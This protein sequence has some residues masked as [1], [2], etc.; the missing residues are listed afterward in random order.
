LLAAANAAY[1]AGGGA[2]AEANPADPYM[3]ALCYFNALREL[4]GARRIVE[5]EVRERVGR[6][7]SKR[8]RVEPPNPVLVDRLIGD[9]LELTSRVSTDDVAKAKARLEKSFHGAPDDRV[10]V[11][12][13]TN[14]ISGGLDSTRLGL[15]IVQGQPKTAAEYIQATSRVGR[16]VDKPGLV[17]TV[18]NVH[19]PRDRAHY[20]S[21][22]LFHRSF[23]RS[24]EATSVTP[25][26]ARALD[27]SLAAVVVSVA[28]HLRPELTPERAV[29]RLRDIPGYRREIIDAIVSRA[30]EESVV[31]GRV[32]LE[33]YIE[34]LLSD[35]ETVV[36]DLE[37]RV[38]YGDRRQ[39][40]QLL[41]VPLD[42][43]LPNLSGSHRRFVAARSMRDV[44]ANVVLRVRDPFGNRFTAEDVP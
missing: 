3:T 43:A 16:A 35:W 21:F 22:H 2:E 19:K 18:L 40:Q 10:D 7:G 30:P 5:D 4:G 31:G 42:T 36:V 8:R 38:A 26:A 44:E 27:R 29:Q 24:V 41:H 6:Y 1:A 11:A 14:M 12:L 9:P 17:V 13:A 23:Y 15:M 25:W 28:R 33:A 39:G 32:V 20:E 37:P 34:G